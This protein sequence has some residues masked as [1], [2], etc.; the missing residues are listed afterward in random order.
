M[1]Y[2]FEKLTFQ[3]LTIDKFK[4]DYGIFYVKGR[5]YAALS[6]R[7]SGS[8]FFKIKETEFKSSE[9]DILFIPEGQDYEVEYYGGESIVIHFV[10]CNYRYFENI[11]INNS[12][13]LKQMFTGLFNCRKTNGS[14]NAQKA[15]IYNILQVIDKDRNTIVKN[16]DTERCANFIEK[17][18]CDSSLSIKMICEYAH[19]SESTLR[20]NFNNNYGISPKRYIL[21]LRIKKAV[22]LLVAGEQKI[23]EISKQCGFEDEK[24]FSRVIKAE[25]G[26]TPSDFLNKEIKK[27]QK[28]L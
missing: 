28:F 21:K 4:H 26:I 27:H 8:G 18:F 3:V 11:T 6:Y 22:E 23:K 17:N 9:G 13:L 2:N 20:R 10:E 7:L 1:I 25:F 15:G 19:I 5:P 16:S 12:E 24:Y 14:V